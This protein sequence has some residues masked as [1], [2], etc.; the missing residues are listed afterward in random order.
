[1]K[2]VANILF[3]LL[4]LQATPSLAQDLPSIWKDAQHYGCSITDHSVEKDSKFWH[5]KVYV[6]Y[7]DHEWF[8]L[9]SIRPDGDFQK[10]LKDCGEW[11]KKAEKQMRKSAQRR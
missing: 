11:M 5:T 4:S 1:L 8:H 2:H 6:K 7:S 10:S 3:T 9:Y